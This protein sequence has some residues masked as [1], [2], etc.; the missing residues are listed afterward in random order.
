[1][2]KARLAPIVAFVIALAC[3]LFLFLARTPPPNITLRYW[4]A[5][6]LSE[7]RTLVTFEVRN[8]KG[9]RCTFIPERL[10]T[11]GASWREC[12]AAIR[13]FPRV[14]G[15]N[16]KLAVPVRQLPAGTQARVVLKRLRERKGLNSFVIRFNLLLTGPDRSVAFAPFGTLFYDDPIEIVS[17]EFTFP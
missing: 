7:S 4:K 8:P 10:E 13:G 5:H 3:V 9:Y 11:N 16:Q 17:E 2:P 14:D 15:A 12:T 1:M 6:Q